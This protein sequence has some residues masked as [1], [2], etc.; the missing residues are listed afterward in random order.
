MTP[1][2]FNNNQQNATSI[3]S[4]QIL[5]SPTTQ[6]TNHSISSSHRGSISSA[7]S[8]P[9][10]AGFTNVVSLRSPHFNKNNNNNSSNSSQ[11]PPPP[12]SSINNTNN[13]PGYR[14]VHPERDILFTDSF[15]KPG[16]VLLSVSNIEVTSYDDYLYIINHI[17]TVDLPFFVVVKRD[18]SQIFTFSYLIQG[19]IDHPDGSVALKKQCMEVSNRVATNSDF[20]SRPYQGAV[21]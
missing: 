11:L 20:D 7:R 2:V 18:N 12:P 21:V 6:T 5:L 3:S 16:D 19:K 14:L 17:I 9:Q 8:V 13:E 15:I 10:S 1:A 4:P